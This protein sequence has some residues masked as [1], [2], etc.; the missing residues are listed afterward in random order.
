MVNRIRIASILLAAAL[1]PAGATLAS[2]DGAGAPPSSPPTTPPADRPANPPAQ[3]NGA[4]PSAKPDSGSG[5][6]GTTDDGGA[7][8][9]PRVPDGAS[10]GNGRFDGGMREGQRGGAARGGMR[11]TDLEIRAWLRSIDEISDSLSAEQM[12]KVKSIRE[13]W[14]AETDKW[15]AANGERMREL[16]SHLA[17]VRRDGGTPDKA[18]TEEMR[19]IIES[20][21]KF[22]PYRERVIGILDPTQAAAQKAAFEKHRKEMMNPSRRGDP[23]GRGA[24]AGTDRPDMPGDPMDDTPERKSDTPARKRDTSGTKTDKPV[25]DPVTPPAPPPGG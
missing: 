12:A 21:P 19:K 3:E 17:G 5:K 6:P 10:Q 4:A 25:E 1:V 23:R 2:S 13:E 9:G 20:R 11:G 22:E 8:R 16:R 14:K 7:L 15:S 24:G 18:L